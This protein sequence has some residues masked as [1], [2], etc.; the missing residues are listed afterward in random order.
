MSDAQQEALEAQRRALSYMADAKGHEELFEEALGLMRGNAD[1]AVWLLAVTRRYIEE[2]PE[3]CLKDADPS[4][5]CRD[6]LN[7]R[8][9]I[10]EF[11]K[12]YA[13]PASR[14]SLEKHALYLT[15]G[16]KD[17]AAELLQKVALR[18]LQ[19]LHRHPRPDIHDLGGWLHRMLM[20]VNIDDQA[21]ASKE[22]VVESLDGD[23]HDQGESQH[24]QSSVQPL[25]DDDKEEVISFIRNLKSGQESVKLYIID[26]LDYEEIAE[27][28]N[29]PYNTVKSHVERAGA[30]II[31]Q[32]TPEK[33]C[34]VLK[35]DPDRLRKVHAFIAGCDRLQGLIMSMYLLQECDCEKIAEILA[36]PLKE[37]KKNV[38][39]GVKELLGFFPKRGQK[40]KKEVEGHD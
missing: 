18:H 25:Y 29:L 20:N 15:K 39:E 6:C 3:K 2:H 21:Q 26:G 9:N 33:R 40:G 12:Y 1:G 22:S 19:H 34:S 4:R 17:K 27:K 37:I 36:L 10:R 24:A 28:L 32:W 14:G 31:M 30:G 16:D 23:E 13:D 38:R 5:V 8:L 11:E 35:G 7:V